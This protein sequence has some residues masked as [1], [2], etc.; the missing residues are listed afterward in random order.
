M[1][2]EWV[3]PGQT[4]IWA[5]W[6][7]AAT[8]E[9][10]ATDAPVRNTRLGWVRGKQATVLGND[11]PVNIFLGIPY[12][13]PPVGPLRFAKP[14]PALPWNDFLN[15]TSYPKLCLQNSEWLFLD[16]H[17]LKVHYPKFGMSEDCLY[18]NIHAPA[19][20]DTGSKLPVMV[21]LPGG[22]FETGSASIFD[23]SAL[24]AYEDVLVVTI[25]YRLGMFGFFK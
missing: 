25:Q 13:A 16:Q 21:W 24:A 22:G 1:S 14:K 2:T 18:L 9:E 17:I 5:V 4:L 8:T 23:G 20:A 19:H 12:A 3:H 6:V 11:K 7:L 10:S 15:A